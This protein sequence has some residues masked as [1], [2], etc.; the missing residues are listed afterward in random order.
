MEPVIL[1]DRKNI[2]D[3]RRNRHERRRQSLSMPAGQDRRKGARRYRRFSARA[4][5]LDTVYSVELLDGKKPVKNP[6]INT[7]SKPKEPQL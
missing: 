3:D 7:T 4:W 1:T 6:A 5:W 2:F